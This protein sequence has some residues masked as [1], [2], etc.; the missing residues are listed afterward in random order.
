MSRQQGNKGKGKPFGKGKPS[1]GRKDNRKPFSKGD[2]PVKKNQPKK[3]GNP[4]E[5]RLNNYIAN[6][7]MR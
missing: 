6:S 5:I 4:D 3:T 2:A 7:E 1:G